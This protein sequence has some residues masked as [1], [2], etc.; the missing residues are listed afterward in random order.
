MSLFV[1]L[2][3]FPCFWSPLGCSGCQHLSSCCC[4][5]L[6]QIWSQFNFKCVINVQFCAWLLRCYSNWTYFRC[7]RWFWFLLLLSR[8]WNFPRSLFPLQFWLISGGWVVGRDVLV[9][10]LPF[11]KI[12]FIVIFVSFYFHLLPCPRKFDTSTYH[13]TK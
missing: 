1:S 8:L 5:C 3:P 12:I 2:S 10:L 6:W 4:G 7:C 11:Q 9:N 13:W